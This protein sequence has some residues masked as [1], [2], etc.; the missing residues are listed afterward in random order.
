[1]ARHPVSAN[2][3]DLPKLSR[4]YLVQLRLHRLLRLR[5]LGG[6][7]RSSHLSIIHP[8]RAL[9]LLA[10][11]QTIV[12]HVLLLRASPL[13]LSGASGPSGPSRE[14]DLAGRCSALRTA[15]PS[16][17]FCQA[18]CVRASGLLAVLLVVLPLFV[19]SNLDSVHRKHMTAIAVVAGKNGKSLYGHPCL[20]QA[21]VYPSLPMEAA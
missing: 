18:V 15:S 4:E 8:A 14:S 13:P 3:S 9:R 12:P 17:V 7:K 20:R 5:I 19:S 1:M 2:S 10:S 16:G 6:S 11:L 21:H